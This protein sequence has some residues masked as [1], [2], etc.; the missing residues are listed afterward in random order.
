MDTF[1]AVP[2]RRIEVRQVKRNP[3]PG[4]LV[5]NKE[6]VGI[7]VGTAQT[8]IDVGNGKRLFYPVD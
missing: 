3:V 8:E 6:R 2:G 1:R 4:G 7:G 5:F